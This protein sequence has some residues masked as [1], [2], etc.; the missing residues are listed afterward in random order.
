MFAEDHSK[1]H[2]N[3]AI[4]FSLFCTVR[5]IRGNLF[6]NHTCSC[7]MIITFLKGF[8]VFF[9]KKE[10]G[11]KNIHL[12]WFNTSSLTV[13]YIIFTLKMESVYKNTIFGLKM[14]VKSGLEKIFLKFLH[15]GD[16]FPLLHKSAQNHK[17]SNK[18]T[19]FPHGVISK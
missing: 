8:I 3:N 1:W 2:E 6:P 15:A 12:L 4:L 18:K 14:T 5:K 9:S 7:I 16:Y 11:W 17:F 10:N 19:N 13:S